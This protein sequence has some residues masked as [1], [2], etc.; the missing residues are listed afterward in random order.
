VVTRDP[1]NMG[2]LSVYG[3]I[4]RLA[5]VVILVTFRR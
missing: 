4:I 2:M 5:D 1:P 3:E